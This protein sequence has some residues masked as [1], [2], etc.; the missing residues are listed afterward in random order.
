MYDMLFQPMKIGQVELKNRISMA[1]MGLSGLVTSEGGF[2]PRG[3]GY[4]VERAKNDVGLLITGCAKVEHEV[5]PFVMPSQ[6]NP[7]FNPAHFIQTSIEMTERIHTYGCKIFLQMTFGFG[8]VVHPGTALKTPVSPSPVPNFWDPS[9]M[10]RELST[11]EIEYLI[12]Q[13]AKAA[14]IARESGFDGIEVHAVHEGYLLDQFTLPIFNQRTDKYGGSPENLLRAP[15]EL[16]Q[17]TKAL[18]GVDFPVMLRYGLKSYMK[19]FHQGIL[20]GEEVV[21]IGRDNTE[22]LAIAPLLEKAGYDAFNADGGVYDSWYWAHPP[23]YMQE[24]T[25]LHLTRELKKVVAVPVIAAGKLGNPDLAEKA[26]QEQW[27]DGIS[28]GRPLLADPQWAKKVRSRQTD[29]IRPC[30]GCHE[31]CLKRIARCK[32]LSCAVNPVTGRETEY[33]FKKTDD[34]KSVYIIGG[35]ISGMEAARISALRGHKV[36]LYESTGALGGHVLEGSRTDFKE[37]DRRLL[38]WYEREMDIL[39]IEVTMGVTA[40]ASFVRSLKPDILFIA[41]GSK[42][43]I[44][45]I[46]GMNTGEERVFTTRQALLGEKTVGEKVIIIGGGLVGCEMAYWLS[47][48]GRQVTLLE[49]LPALMT[50][51]DVPYPNKMMLLELLEQKKISAFTNVSVKAFF[52]EGV[53][54]ED[55]R[56]FQADSIILATGY[57][58]ENSLYKELYPSLNNMYLIGDALQSINIKHAIWSAY[59]VASGV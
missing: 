34:P 26:L 30:I 47:G 56:D 21:E 29:R 25:Y 46:P 23:M 16:I 3:V 57:R 49:K 17:Q 20:P 13:F 43:V 37:D 4:F 5:E 6:P 44:P 8:R 28:L 32:P 42:P 45:P 53:R 2:T 55:G 12:N 15:I 39:K 22:G 40:D 10:C 33:A 52:S 18:A 19:G 27:V 54:L 58:P 31:A 35:G 14:V 36:S 41:T 11:E 38:E 1:P 50:L 48:T 9:I 24:G 51:G 59:E 7:T